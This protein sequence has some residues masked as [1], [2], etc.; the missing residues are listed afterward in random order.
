VGFFSKIKKAFKKVVKGIKKVVKKA[1]RGVKKVVK[2]IGSSKIL[3]ALAIAAAVVVTGGAALTAFG[4]TG[5]MASSKLGAWMMSTSQSVLGGSAFGAAAGKKGVA[6]FL[7]QAGNF[8]AKTVAA[9]FGAVGGAVGSTAR[10]GANLLS[11]N[12]TI[13]QAG[14]AGA[15]TAVTAPKPFSRAA[16]T[17]QNVVS[18]NIAYDA[19]LTGDIKYYNTETGVPLTNDEFARLPESFTNQVN[20]QTPKSFNAEP[21][22]SSTGDILKNAAINQGFSLAGAAIQSEYFGEDP[23]GRSDSLFL[24]GKSSLTP[25]QVWAS[26]NKMDIASIYNS[27]TYGTADPYFAANASLYTQDTIGTPTV[28]TT[29]E[30][31]N[32]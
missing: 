3:K 28:T 15:G 13:F 1:V 4:G 26:E 20:L 8:A 6:K 19:N 25:L 2:K 22:V 21:R 17:G 29:G 5:A 9:P 12:K 11:P 23:R 7:T 24:E 27:P 18:S 30:N 16:L 14:E 32:V 10:V 31:Y